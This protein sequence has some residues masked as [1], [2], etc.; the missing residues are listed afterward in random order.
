MVND[1]VGT[2]RMIVDQTGAYANV[3]RHDYLPFGEE[4][5]AGVGGR[6]SGLGYVAD[7]TRQ[8]FTGY[9]ADG[10]TGLNYAQARYQSSVQGRFISTDPISGNTADPQSWNMYSYVGNSPINRADPTGM[11]Y[12]MGSGAN[13]PWIRENEY[14]VDGFDMSPPGTASNLTDESMLSFAPNWFL[15]NEG[16]PTRSPSSG[17]SA[18]PDPGMP[19]VVIIW[20]GT[21]N[22]G[23]DVSSAFGHVS[24]II[25]DVSYSWEA[26]ENPDT[27]KQE[28]RID[29]LPETYLNDRMRISA[30]KGYVLDFGSWQKNEQFS[31]ALINAYNGTGNYKFLRNN[32]GHEFQRA[33]NQLQLNN[34]STYRGISPKDHQKFITKHLSQYLVRTIEYPKGGWFN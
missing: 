34:G 11:S 29:D 9:E 14:R 16:M 17:T 26:Y 30:G 2:P 23:R 28:W 32:C 7:A 24:Y 6:T 8:R 13:D 10:E 33:V 19:I 5:P 25:N 12:F 27:G 31:Q 22:G 20:E 18:S 1:Q 21:T 4:L 15:L 3:R